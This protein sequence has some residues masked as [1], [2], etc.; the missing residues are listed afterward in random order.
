MR[1]QL[2]L[3]IVALLIP[4]FGWSQSTDSIHLDST[5]IPLDPVVVNFIYSYYEQDGV[6][7]PVTGGIGDEEL[8]DHVG[9]IQVLVPTSSS[10]NLHLSGGMD[11]YT[12]ASTDNIDNEHDLMTT[13]TSAS[14][15]D[16]RK[17]GG[18]GFDKA[19]KDDKKQFGF[20]L[21]YST[22]W[23]VESIN[24]S[25]FF[26]RFSKDENTNLKVKASYFND[27]WELIYPYELR[28]NIYPLQHNRK[29]TYNAS[30]TV[31]QVINKKLRVAVSLENIYQRGLLSTPF[32]RV[33]FTDTTHDIERLPNSRSK[34]P[35]SVFAG[36]YLSDR[37]IARASYRFYFDNFGINAH[38]LNL[39]TPIRLRTEFRIS[40]FYRFHIQSASW[41][42]QPFAMHELGSEFQTS[43]FDLSAFHTHKIGIGIR[44]T[45]IFGFNNQFDLKKEERKIRFKKLEFRTAR[46]YR[47]N[48][49]GLILRA[50]IA[51]LGVSYTID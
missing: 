15:K 12:S 20:N 33:Y 24:G 50:H 26:T 38:T 37:V 39:E 47:V 29:E 23:D 11:S 41:Y 22:E 19:S 4:I 27:R 8:Q 3:Y 34:M 28:P 45:P 35:I 18:I 9:K 16:K 30:V 44:Y 7:S 43:D 40:P 46:Y 31:A 25:A 13:E 10:F 48:Q 51:T 2:K 5:E 14:Y 21:G 6:H 49:D 36:Y 1:M 42:F 32:H 17:Y